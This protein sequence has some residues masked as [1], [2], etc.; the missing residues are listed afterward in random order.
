MRLSCFFF[1]TLDTSNSI[2]CGD[3]M[4]KFI[5][6]GLMPSSYSMNA[7]DLVALN[8]IAFVIDENQA[9]EHFVTKNFVKPITIVMKEKKTNDEIFLL[10]R[11]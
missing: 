11:K 10:K 8:V 2:W 1:I 5:A 4:T 3:D 7:I 9:V 6:M